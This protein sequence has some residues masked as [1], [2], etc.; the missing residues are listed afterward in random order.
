[1]K[2]DFELSISNG[3]R[4]SDQL[5]EALFGDRTVALLVDVNSVRPAWRLS[6]DPHTKP[7]GSPGSGRAH[8]EMTIARMTAINDSPIGLAQRGGAFLQ[9]PVAGKHPIIQAQPR[10]QSVSTWPVSGRP[11][12]R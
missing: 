11:T 6:V 3:L 4:L 5:I 7:H 12:G 1:K 2:L 10:R 8:H 9:S